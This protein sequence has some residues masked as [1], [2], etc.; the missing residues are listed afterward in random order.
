MQAIRKITDTILIPLWIFLLPWQRVWNFEY[1]QG[2]I[3]PT[4][5][6]FVIL[7]LLVII[8]F[9]ENRKYLPQLSRLWPILL[10]PTF[11]LFQAFLFKSSSVVIEFVGLLY[12]VTNF[13]LA[14]FIIISKK[15]SGTR[16][17]ELFTASLALICVLGLLQLFFGNPNWYFEKW[18]LFRGEYPI[19]DEVKML[20]GPNF[21]QNYMAVLLAPAIIWLSLSKQKSKFQWG[22]LILLIIGIAFTFSKNI[23]LT[24]GSVLLFIQLKNPLLRFISKSAAIGM[25]IFALAFSHI[26]IQKQQE[27]EKTP[28]HLYEKIGSFNDSDIWKTTYFLIKE[29]HIELFKSNPLIGVGYGNFYGE[30]KKMI[31]QG[32]F[33]QHITPCDPHSVPFGLLSETG[34][35]GLFLFTYGLFVLLKIHQIFENKPANWVI[36]FG[37]YILL[38]SMITDLINFKN[39]W[40]FLAIVLAYSEQPIKSYA[41]TKYTS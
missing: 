9:E 31:A 15:I 24:T 29:K 1:V 7:G 19:I 32:K 34:I 17:F 27:Y 5:V 23:L 37:F 28:V 30:T 40:I 10:F 3:Q 25:I 11:V 12:V 16:I 41:T 21:N 4:E 2:K 26:L 22:L 38:E 20:K 8:D 13:L 18:L 33:P 39:L 6:I 35:I 36:A 14:Y